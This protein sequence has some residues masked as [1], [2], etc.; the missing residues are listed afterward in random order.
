LNKIPEILEASRTERRRFGFKKQ[1]AAM[2]CPNLK[3]KMFLLA[4]RNYGLFSFA[5]KPS[6]AF[7]YKPEGRGFIPDEVIGFFN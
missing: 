4:F 1:G 5:T 2:K 3:L 7:R 6:H